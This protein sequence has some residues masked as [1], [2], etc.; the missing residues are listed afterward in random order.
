MGYSNGR[1]FRLLY[2]INLTGIGYTVFQQGKRAIDN[3]K[4]IEDVMT[5]NTAYQ[6]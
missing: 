1:S 4:F 5:C 6:V 3:G 2:K